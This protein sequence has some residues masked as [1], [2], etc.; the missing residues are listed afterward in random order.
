MKNNEKPTKETFE[1]WHNDP[2]NWKA[3]FIYYNKADKRL[4]PPKRWGIGW[5]INF[6]N[7]LSILTMFALGFLIFILIRYLRYL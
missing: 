6:A 7:P 5:T 2:S 4:F 1:K 3:G